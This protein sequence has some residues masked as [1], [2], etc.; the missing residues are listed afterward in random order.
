VK[1]GLAEAGWSYFYMAAVKQTA[2]GRAPKRMGS[3]MDTA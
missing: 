1:A 2:F 3:A